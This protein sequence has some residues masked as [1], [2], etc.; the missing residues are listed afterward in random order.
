MLL[1]VLIRTLIFS[2]FMILAILQGQVMAGDNQSS[3]IEIMKIEDMQIKDTHPVSAKMPEISGNPQALSPAAGHPDEEAQA[4]AALPSQSGFSAYRLGPGDKIKITIYGEED[5]SGV[6]T[7]NEKGMI[8]MPLAGDIN[9]QG[10]NVAELK[11][12]LFAAF[13]D[14]Y[15]INPSIAIEV[16]QFRAVYI[17]GE[18]RT[19]GSFNYAAGMSIMN[20]V[21]TAGGFTYRADDDCVEILRENGAA[22]I[23]LEDVK[24]DEKVMPGDIILVKERFF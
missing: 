4:P 20:L 24:L 23:K 6:Y 17:M 19:P 8:A 13:S 15:L 21:A 12:K 9:A 3:P 5:L 7:V 11:N 14:G 10:L 22:Q 18:V 1:K 16:E 2:G